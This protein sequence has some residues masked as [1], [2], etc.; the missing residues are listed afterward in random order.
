MTPCPFGQFLDHNNSPTQQKL[1][2]SNSSKLSNFKNAAIVA[3]FR[4]YGTYPKL[5]CVGTVRGD[6]AAST[7]VTQKSV[8]LLFS[9][10]YLDS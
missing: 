1:T 9:S 5:A 10:D 8:V 3:S 4:A 6:E 7:K 2:G